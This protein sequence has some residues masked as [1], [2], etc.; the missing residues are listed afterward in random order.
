MTD[1]T[2]LALHDSNMDLWLS[3]IEKFRKK[4]TSFWFYIV[5]AQTGQ[6]LQ[7]AEFTLLHQNKVIFESYS[8]HTGAVWFPPLRE[9]DYLLEEKKAPQAYAT[10]TRQFTLQVDYFGS[11]QI[12]QKPVAEFVI[13][14]YS[15]NVERFAGEN[16]GL[17][18]RERLPEETFTV[19]AALAVGS[20]NEMVQV[21]GNSALYEIFF[22]KLE[23]QTRRPLAGAVFE[24]LE[25]NIVLYTAVSN[26][27]GQ[28]HF[29]S[30]PPGIYVLRERRA[31][32]G[33][34]ISK[35]AYTAVVAPDG[36]VTIDGTPAEQMEIYSRQTQGNIT[37]HKYV[38]K[39]EPVYGAKFA[40]MKE[41]VVV[42]QAN[43]DEQGQAYFE[44][45]PPGEYTLVQLVE[46]GV[47]TQ[48]SYAVTVSKSGA[49]AVDGKRTNELRLT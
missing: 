31:P 45:I 24:L 27:N 12:D 32:R 9:G 17:H 26:E 11:I 23:M 37:V 4:Q 16:N 34:R 42:T 19:T 40:L 20:E 3:Y 41:E 15:C 5:D 39:L 2:A 25:G 46:N 10:D 21:C 49:V 35:H 38:Q 14:Y 33:Y 44:K 30:F 29:G 6:G 8:N 13:A 36:T 18:S 1:A 43:T 22:R 47:A 7:G 48:E 28:V